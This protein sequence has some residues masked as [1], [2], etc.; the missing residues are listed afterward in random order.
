V[1]V[2]V[3]SC[4]PIYIL[5]DRR[6]WQT[7]ENAGRVCSATDLVR[8]RTPGATSRDNPRTCRGLAL[9]SGLHYEFLVDGV[10]TTVC[11]EV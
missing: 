2:P 7:P 4:S 3:L 8:V 1:D 5:R 6:R 10:R 9:A 11:D